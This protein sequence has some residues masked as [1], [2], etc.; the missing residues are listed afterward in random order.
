MTT[1]ANEQ[2]PRPGEQHRL[3][4]TALV[5]ASAALVGAVLVTSLTV[6]RPQAGAS[7]LTPAPASDSSQP[8]TS[9][10]SASAALTAGPSPTSADAR[11]P[12]SASAALLT[13]SLTSP[14]PLVA[15]MPVVEMASIVNRGP[16]L[17]GVGVQVAVGKKRSGVGTTGF[18]NTVLERWNAATASWEHVAP[19]PDPNGIMRGSFP[20]DI[21]SGPS[22]LSL[23]ITI[24]PG[25]LP[26]QSGNQA[27]LTITL[28]RGTAV[29]GQQQL[30]LSVLAPS[31]AAVSQPTTM[32]RTGQ[33]EFD[34]VIQN[35]TGA[36]YPT[37]SAE[38]NM[39]CQ[40]STIVCNAGSGSMLAGFTVDWFGGAGWT[41]LA[42][43][44]TPNGETLVESSPLPPGSQ[45]VRIRLSFG[46]DLDPHAQSASL[47]LLVG[48]PDVS[49]NMV[50]W[51]KASPVSIT[52]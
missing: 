4:A 52:S 42:V 7:L 24:G 14:Q 47:M 33:A 19:S 46:A 38:L 49:S 29:M 32:Q 17:T 25:F 26:Q 39:V 51:A 10:V 5:V 15:Q 45:Q 34:F 2:V 28:A 9:A 6:L 12:A 41:P 3:R 48:P 8:P 1:P 20:S 22:S 23:R 35:S 11:A 40:T 21:P 50:A 18:E 43:G 44:G 36:T 31:V 37:F 27:P 16:A 30:T 13:V